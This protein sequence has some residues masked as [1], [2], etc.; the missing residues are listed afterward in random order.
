MPDPQRAV[1]GGIDCHTDFHVVAALD[2]L[3]RVLG[4]ESF[5]AT[6]AGYRSAHMWLASFGQI[7]AV[8]VESTGSYGAALTRSLVEWGCRVIE[9]NQPHPHLRSRRGKND[10]IDA[11][12][13]ARKVLSGEATGAAKDTTGIVEAIRQL[14]VTRNSAVKARAAALCQLGDLLVTAPTALRERLDTRRTLE[15]KAAVCARLRPDTDRLADPAQAAKAALRSLG[16]RVAQLGAE[17]D[18]LESPARPAGR[19]RST[20]NPVTPGM[21]HP[22]HRD[23]ARRR[24]REHRPARLRS[25]LRSPVRSRAGP[26]IQRAHQ[27]PPAQ[28]RRQP[29]RQPRPA[30][31]R[32]RPAPLLRTNPQLHGPPPRRR[33][34]QKR[35]HPLPQTLRRPRALP[36]TASRPRHPHNPHLT[37]IGTSRGDS[38]ASSPESSTAP[39]EPTSPPSQP[40]LDIYRNVPWTAALHYTQICDGPTEEDFAVRVAEIERLLGEADRLSQMERAMR[41]ALPDDATAIR[42]LAVSPSSRSSLRRQRLNRWYATICPMSAM[43]APN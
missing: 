18:E 21:R 4:T 29:R 7:A 8:G 23:A 30:H 26:R 17:A 6:G 41:P 5:P 38:N 20:H 14:S 34:N 22:P 9:I 42:L 32:H 43:C 3:G 15:G 27:P 25:L 13:A 36:H 40:A 37:S 19:R 33:Q 11:E 1:I 10:T 12:A 28:L 39:C 2:P 16:R 35:S 31:D 24:G